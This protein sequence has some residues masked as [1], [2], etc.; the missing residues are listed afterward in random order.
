MLLTATEE[1]AGDHGEVFTRRWV[2]ELILDLC[3]YVPE[4]DLTRMVAMEPACGSGAFLLPM[5]SRL[6][7]SATL[8]G[9]RLRDTVDSIRATDLLRVNVRASRSAV[10]EALT[11]AGA[12]A[13]IAAALVEAWI[14]PGNFL[15]DP[16]QERT[17]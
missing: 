4:R 8:H 9:H 12:A 1:A 16:P 14:K 11:E 13:N 10:R 5:V 6:L 7:A 15:L 2:V 3:G 17:V